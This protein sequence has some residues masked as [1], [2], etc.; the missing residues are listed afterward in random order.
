MFRLAG[1][2]A[3]SWGKASNRIFVHASLRQILFHGDP[4]A[5]P[6]DSKSLASPYFI[7]LM[8]AD[9]TL[10]YAE[11]IYKFFPAWVG[12][13]DRQNSSNRLERFKSFKPPALP[14]VPDSKFIM[15]HLIFALISLPPSWAIPDTTASCGWSVHSVRP[16]PVFSA[17]DFQC[18]DAAHAF[19]ASS[20]FV[21]K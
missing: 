10:T 11:K 13:Q 5:L 18:S 16:C 21:V 6:G 19:C 14:E 3:P 4:S 12:V 2:A 8:H 20:H 15:R 7:T 9:M 17:F 1:S